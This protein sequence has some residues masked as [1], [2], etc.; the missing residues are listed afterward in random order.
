MLEGEIDKDLQNLHQ[1]TSAVLK[2]EPKKLWSMEIWHLA[3]GLSLFAVLT[4]A[5]ITMVCLLC[6]QKKRTQKALISNNHPIIKKV[7]IERQNSDSSDASLTPLVKIDCQH[8]ER[9]GNNRSRLS[10]EVT[11]YTEY[12]I[13]LDPKWEFSRTKLCIGKPLGEGA[14]GQVFK[15]EAHGIDGNPD[16]WTI[17]AV[18]MLK[19]GHSDAELANLILEVEVMKGIGRHRNIINLL[20]CCTQDGQF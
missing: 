17:A 6:R 12:E 14:F 9:C 5:F 19:E 4:F 18:K 16:M 1:S 10:S 20:G 11:N 13:P 7:Y 3:V 15:A 8:I 2:N